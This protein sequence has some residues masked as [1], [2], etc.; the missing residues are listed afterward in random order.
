MTLY[1]DR[2]TDKTLFGVE[3]TAAQFGAANSFFIFSLAPL[4]AVL[5]TWLSR[6]GWEP[7]TPV[8]FALGITQAGLGF[9][10]QCTVLNFLTKPVC[11]GMVA[12]VPHAY[13]GGAVPQPV[14]LSRSQSSL[15][16]PSLAL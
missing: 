2:V 6:R 16:L 5:W 9:G 3:L 11:I 8:K 1:T 7:G 15:C 10:A 14:G 12:D 13:H 4:F